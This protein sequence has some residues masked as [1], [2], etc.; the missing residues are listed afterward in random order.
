MSYRKY[1]VLSMLGIVLTGCANQIHDAVR[2]SVIGLLQPDQVALGKCQT[3]QAKIIVKVSRLTRLRIIGEV[4]ID[5]RRGP[6]DSFK[7][8]PKASQSAALSR[9]LRPP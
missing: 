8:A 7:I 1:L 6:R 9:K 5:I 2:G 4:P 3:L